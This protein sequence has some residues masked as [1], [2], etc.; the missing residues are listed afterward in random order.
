V[1]VIDQMQQ[2]KNRLDDAIQGKGE[3]CRTYD[4]RSGWEDRGRQETRPP[5]TLSALSGGVRWGV[6]WMQPTG[7]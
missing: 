4:K 2:N 1:P 5:P 6:G 7:S 3:G